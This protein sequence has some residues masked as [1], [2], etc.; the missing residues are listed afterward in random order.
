MAGESINELMAT[1]EVRVIT[2]RDNV[3]GYL[4]QELVAKK[5]TRTA[6]SDK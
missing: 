2:G 6:G 3:A 5:L 1:R 4:C